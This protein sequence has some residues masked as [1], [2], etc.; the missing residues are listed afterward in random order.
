MYGLSV[1][2]IHFVE[3]SFNEAGKTV[4]PVVIQDPYVDHSDRMVS[5]YCISKR[6]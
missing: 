2:H 1:M 6:I 3:E 4:K 5:S